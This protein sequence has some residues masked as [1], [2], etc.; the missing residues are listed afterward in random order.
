MDFGEAGAERL[1]DL[2]LAWSA[3]SDVGKVRRLNED[4][5]LAY[6]GLFVVADG[7]GGHA[8][9]EVASRIAVEVFQEKLAELPLIPADVERLMTEANRRVRER[10]EGD[11][12]EGMGTTLVGLVLIDN[13]GAASL[14][15]FNIGDSRCYAWSAETGLEQITTDHSVVQELVDTGTISSSDA[16]RH[17]DRNV[18]TRAIGVEA[19]AAADFFVLPRAQHQRFLLCSDGV[20]DQLDPQLIAQCLGEDGASS[21]GAVNLLAHVLEGPASDNATCIVVDARWATPPSDSTEKDEDVTGPRP[22]DPF[23]S[24]MIRGVPSGLGSRQETRPAAVPISE[25]PR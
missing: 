18:V 4:S 14:M 21:D 2:E 11:S 25:V 8:A 6:P 19:V 9:G 16:R 12:T 7:M 24:G 1:D 23:A 3:A 22:K 20:S 10:A 13:G 15:V 17:P 5:F